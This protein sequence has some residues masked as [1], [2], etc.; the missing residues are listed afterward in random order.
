MMSVCSLASDLHANDFLFSVPFSKRFV[1]HT[2][3]SHYWT[4]TVNLG[5]AVKFD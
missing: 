2:A 4:F 5:P 3:L 1:C